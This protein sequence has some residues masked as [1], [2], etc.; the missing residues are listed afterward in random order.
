MN[1]KNILE[2]FEENQQYETCNIEFEP[3]GGAEDGVDFRP[4]LEMQKEN[5]QLR[6]NLETLIAFTK[7]EWQDC[8]TICSILGI[9]FS[10]AHGMFD[11]SRTAEWNP[12]PLNGQK[13]TTKF[14]PKDI[15][16]RARLKDL[17]LQYA[18]LGHR[19]QAE[20]EYHKD[21]RGEMIDMLLNNIEEQARKKLISLVVKMFV[22]KF[23]GIYKNLDEHESVPLIGIYNSIDFVGQELEK[24]YVR[25]FYCEAF[26]LQAKANGHQD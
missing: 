14:R 19:F 22:E 23:K 8:E 26:D 12:A 16:L 1:G 24:M 7:G 4:V 21:L 10:M 5:I 3:F 11:F 9:D 25:A 13:I 6:K 18:E 20:R 17:G 2:I 15:A